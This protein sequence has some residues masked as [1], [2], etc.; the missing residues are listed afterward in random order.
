MAFGAATDEAPRRRPACDTPADSASPPGLAADVQAALSIITHRDSSNDRG[1]ELNLSGTD[2]RGATLRTTLYGGHL[3]LRVNLKWANL[4]KSRLEET[5]LELADLERANLSEAHLEGAKL[6]QANLDRAHLED[7]YLEGADL[8]SAT[9]KSAHMEGAT[10]TDALLEGAKLDGATYDA[11]T[12]WPEGFDP[13][14][15]GARNP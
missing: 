9:L 11:R 7:A 10:L 8:R 5:D 4:R 12:T 14:S 6:I 1:L 13:L 3:S 2:L 15:A